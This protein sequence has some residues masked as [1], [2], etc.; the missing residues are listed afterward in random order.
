M[1]SAHAAHVRVSRMG[2]AVMSY[3]FAYEG[4]HW[5]FRPTT[6]SMKDYRTKTIQRM[7][8]DRRARGGCGK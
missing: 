6:E 4:G 7:A 3:Q 2:I 8:A 5:R 1:D